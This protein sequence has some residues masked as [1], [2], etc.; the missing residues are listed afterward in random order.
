[1]MY[2]YKQVHII[3]HLAFEDMGSFAE[4]LEAEGV[5][6]RYYDAGVDDLAQLVPT[7]DELLVVLGGPISAND[8]ADYPFLATE[9]ALLEKRLVADRPTLGICLGAQLMAKALGA[10]VYPGPTKE[11]GWAPIELSEA[12]KKSALSHLGVNDT[13]LLHWHG[14]TFDMPEHAVHLAASADYRHQAFSYGQR[15]LALQFHPEVTASGLER[16]YIGHSTEIQHT[17]KLSVQRLRADAQVYAA[18]LQQQSR[19]FIRDW[20]EQLSA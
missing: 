12:G 16:W 13:Q 11:I 1:M 4:V 8:E 7:M 20:L 17:Q 3:R 2:P 14:E 9:L 10:R 18:D 6:L 15:A 19:A 5:S